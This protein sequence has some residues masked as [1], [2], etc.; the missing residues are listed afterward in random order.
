MIRQRESQQSKKNQFPKRKSKKKKQ[1]CPKAKKFITQEKRQGRP[2]VLHLN[3]LI[4]TSSGIRRK[5]CNKQTDTPMSKIAL[6]EIETHGL[7]KELTEH[8]NVL[9]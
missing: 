7:N 8:E 9:R 1:P 4:S 6:F 5:F 2:S 3:A